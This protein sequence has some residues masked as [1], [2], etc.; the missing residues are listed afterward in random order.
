VVA[1]ETSEGEVGFELA[2][3]DGR[4]INGEEE[5]KVVG[6]LFDELGLDRGGRGGNF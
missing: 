2:D 5:R 4:R 6:V 3:G 1:I